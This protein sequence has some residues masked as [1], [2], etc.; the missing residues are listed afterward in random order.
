MLRSEPGVVGSLGRAVLPPQSQAR[1]RL[2]LR[3]S[4]GGVGSSWVGKPTCGVQ[5]G[6]RGQEHMDGL[7]ASLHN[8]ELLLGQRHEA[9][10][11]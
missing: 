7:G 1:P 4:G 8:L 5:Q 2:T 6:L 9:G 3:D 11:L 10:A